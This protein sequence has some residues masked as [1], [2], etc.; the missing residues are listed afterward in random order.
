VLDPFAG[1]GTTG[2]VAVRLGRRFVGIDINGG[3]CDLGGHTAQQRVDAA[4]HGH[5]LEAEIAGQT[6]MLGLL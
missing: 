4:G 1:S 5:S 3:D 2:I 6:T